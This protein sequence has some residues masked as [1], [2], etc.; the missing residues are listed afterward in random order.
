MGA[1]KNHYCDEIALRSA[2]DAGEEICT[3]CN[4]DLATDDGLC[5]ACF[6]EINGQFGVGA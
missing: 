6:E 1:V 3:L 2:A 5:A 4:S